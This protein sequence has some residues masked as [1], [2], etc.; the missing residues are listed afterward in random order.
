MIIRV[1]KGMSYYADCFCFVK[2][3]LCIYLIVAKEYML[4]NQLVFPEFGD[5][6]PDI[7]ISNDVYYRYKMDMMISALFELYFTPIDDG[8]LMNDLER[9]FIFKDELNLQL[10]DLDAEKRLNNPEGVYYHKK[11]SFQNPVTENK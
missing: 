1:I 3:K 6:F 8:I 2:R 4:T 11:I 10:E 5:R 9:V 7:D